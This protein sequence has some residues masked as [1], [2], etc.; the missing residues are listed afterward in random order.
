MAAFD[1]AAGLSIDAIETDIQPSADGALVLFHDRTLGKL[2][3][4]RRRVTGMSL[5]QLKELDAG[6]WYGEAFAGERM[7]TLDELLDRHGGQVP[8]LLELKERGGRPSAAKHRQMAL[9]AG[10]M[11]TERGLTDN[12]V[13]LG[14]GLDLLRYCWTHLPHLR[15]VWNMKRPSAMTA[16]VA[17]AIAPLFGLCCRI[18]TLTP[19]WVAWAHHHGKPVLCYTINDDAALERAMAAGVDGL[20][21]DRPDWLLKRLGER[22]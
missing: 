10:Q 4:P 13:M 5:A 21:S 6:S 12:T 14:F 22:A 16:K 19:T 8:L 20:I 3:A 18:T 17:T 15:Y 11:V 1:L 2:G 9:R 7:V